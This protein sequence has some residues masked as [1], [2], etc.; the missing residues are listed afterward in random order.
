MKGKN[1]CPGSSY[2]KFSSLEEVQKQV[3]KDIEEAMQ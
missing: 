3:K 1:K 2:A